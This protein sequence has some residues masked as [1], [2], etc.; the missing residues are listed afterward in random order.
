MLTRD[1]YTAGVHVSTPVNGTTWQIALLPGTYSPA[2]SAFRTDNT[3]ADLSSVFSSQSV[4]TV[5]TGFSASGSVDSSSSASYTVALQPGLTT[6]SSAMYQGSSTRISPPQNASNSTASRF[7]QKVESLLLT[8][9]TVAIARFASDKS[10]QMVLW[11]SLYDAGQLP[12][13][14]GSGG[15]DIVQV[16]SRACTPP[17]SSGGVCNADGTCACAPGFTGKT[18]G[19]AKL[20][21]RLYP[22]SQMLIAKSRR[23]LLERLLRSFLLTLS[24]QLYYLRRGN[25]WYRYLS[26]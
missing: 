12:S 9:D 22:E 20:P 3:S 10:T 14:A 7:P 4:P 15:L 18:C 17:C 21:S 16:Q 8:S 5:P 23:R 2:T 24:R 1:R 26:R 6:Y 13:G 19:T 25:K 11:D